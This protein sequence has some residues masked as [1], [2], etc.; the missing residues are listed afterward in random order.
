LK[1]KTM[2][3]LIEHHE[4]VRFSARQGN[5]QVT[6]DLPESHGGNDQGMSPPQLFVSAI[7][8]CIGVYIADYCDNHAIQYQGMRLHLDWKYREK[9]R[10]I[11]S[12]RV[13]V[14]LPGG[15]LPAEH[16]QGIQNTV[17]HCLLHNTLANKPE[18]V[19]DVL[20]GQDRATDQTCA[21][22]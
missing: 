20:P 14:E 8:A 15:M 6:I 3:I 12:V 13:R 21:V 7:G 17:Q 16:E 9:P 10:R 18:F 4:D 22:A 5:H 1:E 11:S 2:S 19:V